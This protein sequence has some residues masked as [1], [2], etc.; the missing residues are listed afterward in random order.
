[1]T[2]VEE[3]VVR[4]S[5][6]YNETADDKKTKRQPPYA[7]IV[8]NDDKHTFEYVIDLL[9]KVFCYPAEKAI[10][11]ATEIDANGRTPVWSGSKEVAE[12]HCERIRSGG[13]DFFAQNPVTFPLGCYI[14]EMP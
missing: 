13:I 2:A 3:P 4:T 14:E 8:E 9:M 5:D 11:L 10:Q 7:V 1:M 6:P 12:F